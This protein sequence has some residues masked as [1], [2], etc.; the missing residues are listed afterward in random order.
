M[1]KQFNQSLLGFPGPLIGHPGNWFLLLDRGNDGSHRG[2]DHGRCI[3]S[4]SFLVIRS[5]EYH[6]I[7]EIATLPHFFLLYWPVS[8]SPSPTLSRWAEDYFSTRS[9]T[10]NYLS[11]KPGRLQTLARGISPPGG[12]ILWDSCEETNSLTKLAATSWT[13][14]TGA[15]S[16]DCGV[17]TN[18]GK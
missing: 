7:Q 3:G 14:R 2:G 15:V 17:G 10:T 4:L 12:K 16:R 8:I 13:L 9:L 5:S 1:P 11:E 18:F 6:P